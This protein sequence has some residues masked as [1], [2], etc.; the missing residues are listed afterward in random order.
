MNFDWNFY[1]DFY[2]EFKLKNQKEAY[3]HWIKIGM[4]EGY[5]CNSTKCNFDWKFYVN[6]YPN[7]KKLTKEQ[8]YIHF[9]N[10]KYVICCNIKLKEI[11]EKNLSLALVQKNNYIKIK[12]I[13][14]KLNILIRTSNRSEYFKEA[15]ESIINQ[16]YSN[17][18]IY[19]SYDKTESLNYLN[20]YNNISILEMNINNSNKYKFNLYNNYLMDKVQD[21]YILFLDDDDIYVHDNVFNIINDNLSS[22]ND[23]L[24]WKFMRPDKIIYP[25]NQNNICLG[26][27]DTTSFCFHSNFKSLARWG[28]KQCGD[29]RFVNMLLN[30]KKFNI[31]IIDYILTKTIFDNKMASFGN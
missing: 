14:E 2:K 6:Y 20:N 31:K 26:S 21:G 28:D 1:S 8:A 13:E 7:I 23:F 22:T 29:F 30:K 25:K 24:I 27:I 19:V 11:Y 12:N 3:N 18:K 15:I 5:I 16:K 4:K 17:Y 10:S 9:I